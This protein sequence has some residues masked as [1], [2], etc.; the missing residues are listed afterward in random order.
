MSRS[1]R[2]QDMYQAY[3]DCCA[4]WMLQ[5]LIALKHEKSYFP[6]KFPAAQ[7]VPIASPSQRW[8]MW[9]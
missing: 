6:I 9:L 2:T 5:T 4:F 7:G 8:C 3:L 1:Q